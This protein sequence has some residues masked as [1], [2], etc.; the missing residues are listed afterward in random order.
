MTHLQTIVKIL[1]WISIA[2]IA[3][4][5]LSCDEF[6]EEPNRTAA[7][8]N[9]YA[10]GSETAM[11]MDSIWIQGVGNDSVLYRNKT[12]PSTDVPSPLLPLNPTVD[13]T[14]YVITNHKI[15][16]TITV[17]YTRYDG[18]ISSECG[19]AAFAEIIEASTNTTHHSIKGIEVINTKVSTV[20]YRNGVIN[21]ENIRIY[22]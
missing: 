6:C 13:V 17:T 4:A 15:A 3:W 22:Y 16:D 7:V 10:Q 5:V 1:M 2:S 20:N 19:C 8:I 9:F 18:F 14:Q 12:F 21:A 11:T